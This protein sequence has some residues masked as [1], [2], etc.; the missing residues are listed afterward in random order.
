MEQSD[1]DI[2]QWDARLKEQLKR[3]FHNYHKRRVDLSV[4]RENEKLDWTGET[5]IVEK[6][7][8][9]D[10]IATVRLMFLDADELTLSE[11]V[12]IESIFNKVFISNAAQAGEWLDVITGINFN[13]KKK[14]A[15]AGGGL[16]WVDRGDPA[17]VDF[18]KDDLTIDYN[19]HELDLSTIIPKNAKL[20][21][22]RVIVNVMEIGRFCRFR[23]AGNSNDYNT[24]KIRTQAGAAE[25][26]VTTFVS[27]NTDGVVEYKIQTAVWN[28]FD[29]TV[30]GWFV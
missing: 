6:A 24:V 22:L 28:K 18:D 29:I 12:E 15:E 27:C 2:S 21:M 26:A 5:I 16:T 9:A 7:S 19:W 25:Y 30:G 1:R 10:A 23:K 3:S 8:S 4:A 11:N 13:Y 17:S 20:V 14:I